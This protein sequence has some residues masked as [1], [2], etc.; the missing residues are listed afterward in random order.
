[1]PAPL[2]G[3]RCRAPQVLKATLLCR[4]E[5]S[6]ALQRSVEALAMQDLP[7]ALRRE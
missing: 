6:F 7:S 2:A 3:S 1:M 4:S 5:H